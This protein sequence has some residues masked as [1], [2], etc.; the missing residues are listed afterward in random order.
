M[1][2]LKILFLILFTLVGLT[3]CLPQ[4]TPPP[5]TPSPTPVLIASSP[6][7]T[8]RP[9]NTPIPPLNS[10]NGPPLRT[11]EMFA[12]G[13]GWGLIYNSLLLTHDG[14]VSWFSVPFTQGTS[15]DSL[16]NASTQVFYQD[17]N[18]LYTVVPAQDGISGLLYSTQNG[19]GTW[20]VNP[21]P[22][23]HGQL[24]FV[25]HTGYFLEMTRVNAGNMIIALFTSKDNGLTWNRVY[26]GPNSEP[27]NSVPL[28]GQKTGISFLNSDIGWLGLASIPKKAE[29]YR[30]QDGGNSWAIQ[31]IPAPQNITSLKVSSLPPIFF[32][33][34][35]TDG[36]LPVDYT[37]ID[38]GDR[39]R[40]FYTSMDSGENWSPGDSVIDGAAYTFLDLQTG[41][42][43]GKRGLYFTNDGAKN[44][45]LLPVA[46]SSSEHA[47]SIRFIDRTTGWLL[48]TDA[49]NR[50]RIYNTQDG[51]NTWTAVNP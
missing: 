4:P 31:E 3:A 49:K 45:Q 40:V 11:L 17:V 46:F 50:V 18:T 12:G 6:Q 23:L 21:V 27:S 15:V 48:T 47:T 13:N 1:K 5:L 38:T 20:Q 2:K 37:S 32:V 35:Q 28:E 19:G 8:S 26:P 29:I 41:W 16:I 7:P 42:T 43:W 30:T 39:N 24:L 51:G 10:P 9:T 36:L 33:G 14:G 22:F 44:W 25:D 34:N